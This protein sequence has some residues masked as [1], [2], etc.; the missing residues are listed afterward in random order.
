[1]RKTFCLF[2]LTVISYV[3]FAQNIASVNGKAISSKEFMWVYKKN[4]S[5][6][7]KTITYTDLRAYLDLYL[8]FKLKV[9]EAKNLSMDT[10]TAYLKEIN[11]YE[12][13]LK[14]Q[15][16]IAAKNADYDFILNEY[17][18]GVLM[19]NVSEKK[20]WKK[21]QDDENQLQDYYTKNKSNYNN[22]NLDEIRGQVI[23]DYQQS[24]ENEWVKALRQKHNVKIYES[25]LKKIAKL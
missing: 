10:D 19:F 8:N 24:L 14:A 6:N 22:Q 20:I 18:E 21:A 12:E 3:T 1:M 7:A 23:A 13:A 16:K 5:V 17:K 2:V 25:D 15:K 9:L 4:H 11:G